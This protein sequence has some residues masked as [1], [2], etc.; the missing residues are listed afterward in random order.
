MNCE[1]SRFRMFQRQKIFK[2]ILTLP[3]LYS[4]Q[5]LKLQAWEEK[6]EDKIRRLRGRE[7]KLLRTAAILNIINMFSWL[8]SPVLVTTTTFVTY[9]FVSEEGALD[10][11][12]AFVSLI[13]FNTQHPHE[14]IARHYH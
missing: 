13:L 11:N 5:V 2:Y 12:T 1:E 8:C 9:I 10:S 6:F 3:L 4:F 7:L 14:Q